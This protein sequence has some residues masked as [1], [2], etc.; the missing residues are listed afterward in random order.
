MTQPIIDTLVSGLSSP[1]AFT[2]T[3]DNRFFLTEKE[4]KI[5]TFTP[6][7]NPTLFYDVSDSTF[8][9][10]ERGLLGI[11]IDPLYTQNNYVYFYYNHLHGSNGQRIR[12]VRLTNQNGVGVNPVLSYDH[13]VGGQNAI[14]GNHVGGN[15]RFS[16]AEPDKLYLSIGDVAVSQY[17]QILTNPYGKM[18]RMNLDGSA[19]SDNPFYDDGNLTSGN[20]D[21]IYSYGLRN[22]FD[23]C[24][25]TVNDSLYISE[26]GQIMWDE[27][28]YGYRAGNF[29]WPDCEGFMLNGSASSPCTD[30]D[31]LLP[32]SVWGAPLPSVT[33]I[34]FYSHFAFSELSNTLLVADNDYGQIWKLT[35]G[36][37]PAYN[38]VTDQSLWLDLIPNSSESGLTTLKQSP[39]GCIYAM[40]GGYTQNGKIFRLCSETVSATYK[41]RTESARLNVFPNPTTNEII[42]GESSGDDAFAEV[43]F[44]DPVGRLTF[45]LFNVESGKTVDISHLPGGSYILHTISSKGEQKRALLVVSH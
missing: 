4:G 13:F 10:F 42:L 29:G 41:S 8:N 34:E 40:Q 25:S 1:I 28:S 2:F 21:L 11:E 16:P 19:P 38:T 3:P 27:V 45:R 7:N 20:Y 30:P 39:E 44:L 37:A 24:F 17:S 33:G 43:L 5:W 22:P 12:V 23:F 14:N 9:N 31:Y 26:N 35:L 6:G 15:I 32:M 36:N 18:L